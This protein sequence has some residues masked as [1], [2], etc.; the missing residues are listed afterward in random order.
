MADRPGEPPY[1]SRAPLERSISLP[2]G[3]ARAGYVALC[4]GNG[5]YAGAAAQEAVSGAELVARRCERLGFRVTRCL[6]KG[7]DELLAAVS[8]FTTE[9]GKGGT[10][11]F[12]FAG[13][14][15]WGGCF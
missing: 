12:Y 4:I 11:V 14:L 8:A 5:A 9:L 10:G 7:V 2:L 15:G 6:D 1:S 13:A 3:S